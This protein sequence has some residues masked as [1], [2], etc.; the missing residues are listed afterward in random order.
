MERNEGTG[1]GGREERG[2]GRRRGDVG[3]GGTDGD[4]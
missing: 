4:P 3:E 1:G 2:E